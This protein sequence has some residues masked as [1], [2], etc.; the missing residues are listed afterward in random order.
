MVSR[1]SPDR[2]ASVKK[3]ELLA[4]ISEIWDN[5]P[6]GVPIYIAVINA[7]RQARRDGRHKHDPE[8]WIEQSVEEQI[9]HALHHLVDYSHGTYLGVGNQRMDIEHVVCRF[10]ILLAQLDLFK[11]GFTRAAHGMPNERGP[12]LDDVG[13]GG[14]E[15]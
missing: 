5:D 2:R 3:Q 11:G 13:S 9:H 1:R 10:G 4:K 6:A 15:S 7:V 14:E 12:G 8:S